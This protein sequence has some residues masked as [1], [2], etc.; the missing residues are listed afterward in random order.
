MASFIVVPA[1]YPCYLFFGIPQLLR[2]VLSSIFISNTLVLC[3]SLLFLYVQT[4]CDC[5][6]LY[7]GKVFN[8]L[9]S[10]GYYTYIDHQQFDVT[11]QVTTA[12]FSLQQ[13]FLNASQHQLWMRPIVHNTDGLATVASSISVCVCVRACLRTC[14]RACAR[15]CLLVGHDSEPCKNG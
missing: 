5:V 11:D 15:V 9:E 12:T 7:W 14:M 10:N 13:R 1:C 4:I 6:K 2:K 8:I 3:N